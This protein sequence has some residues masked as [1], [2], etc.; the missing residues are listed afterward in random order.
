MVSHAFGTSTLRMA[1]RV[2]FF[3][4]VDLEPRVATNLRL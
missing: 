4:V 1:L 3:E 2:T